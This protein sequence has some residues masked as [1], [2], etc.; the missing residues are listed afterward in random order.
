MKVANESFEIWQTTLRHLG[1]VVTYQNCIHEEIKSRQ[2]RMLSP[3]LLSENVKVTTRNC[4]FYGNALS[5]RTLRKHGLRVTEE[6]V[7]TQGG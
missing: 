7:W 1:T 3:C 2:F 6:N 5:S 4:C